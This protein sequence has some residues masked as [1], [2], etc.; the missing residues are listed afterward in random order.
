MARIS[1]KEKE[2]RVLLKKVFNT[3]DGM[4]LLKHLEERFVDNSSYDSDGDINRT[5]YNLGQKELVQELIKNISNREIFKNLSIMNNTFD[6]G[7]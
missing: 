4:K 6:L 1:S 5:V 3:P 7:E 2:Y